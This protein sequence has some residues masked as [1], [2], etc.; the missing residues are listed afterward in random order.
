MRAVDYR[1]FVAAMGLAAIAFPALAHAS[2]DEIVVT[3]GREARQLSQIGQSVSVIGEEEIVTRQSVSVLD[4]LR[5]VPGL[6]FTR[7]GG[8]GTAASVFLRGGESAQTVALIDGVKLNDPASPQGGFDF[9]NLLIGNIERIELVRGPQSLVWGS[10]AIGGVINFITRTPTQDVQSHLRAEYG[11]RDSTN[12]VGNVSGTLGRVQSSLGAGFFRSDGLSAFNAARGGQELDGYRNFGANAKFQVDLL[13]DLA[14]DLRGYYSSGRTEIDGFAPPDFV[15]G[16]TRETSTTRELVAYSGVKAALWNGRFSNRLGAA[17]TLTDRQNIDPDGL[18]PI[19]FASAGE[20]IRLEYQGGL[21]LLPGLEA[22]FGAETERSRFE[23][24]SFGGPPAI[25]QVRITGV[26]AQFLAEP[27]R[28]LSLSGGVRQ[29]DHSQFA[30]VTSFAA[31]GTYSPN[32][33]A[34]L[35]RFSFGEGFRAPSLF[36]LF[37]DFGNPGLLP[38]TSRGWD[39]GLAQALLGGRLKL[40]ATLFRR[41]S[42]QQIQFISCF[43]SLAAICVNRPFGVYDNVRRTRAQGAELEAEFSP[44]AR[45]VLRANYSYLDAIAR[46]TGLRLARRPSHSANASLDYSWPFGLA[47][48][49]SLSYVGPRFDDG[50]NSQIVAGYVLIDVRAS[51]RLRRHLEIYGRI[52]NLAQDEY[53]TVFQF[54][55]PRRGAFIGLRWAA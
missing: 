7:S 6:S 32:F 10:Q 18:P 43:G 54:G 16:D 20:N 2:E 36:E 1:S 40:N 53:E 24:E 28:G 49:A 39:G 55:S 30:G 48:G 42:F 25:A 41:E 8:P 3:A 5:T 46:D 17:Y 33:G 47:A 51:Y 12:V 11:W 45:L 37:S 19:T 4:A 15:F 44:G 22:N 13:S 26:Y 9:G 50:A 14:L 35:I 23:S 27:I 52:E 31:S 34:S 21:N 29:D 38:E